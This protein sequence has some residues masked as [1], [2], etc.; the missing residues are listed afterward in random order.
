LTEC[1]PAR[2]NHGRLHLNFEAEIAHAFFGSLVRLCCRWA[3]ARR[4]RALMNPDTILERNRVCLYGE[5]RSVLEEI[6]SCS[7]NKRVI[8]VVGRGARASFH[9][10]LLTAITRSWVRR[11][12]RVRPEDSADFSRQPTI[13]GNSCRLVG[14]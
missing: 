4:S 9:V 5:R 14:S 1:V 6:Y 7:C 12:Q 13:R 2:N 8:D 3:R 11:R 10:K